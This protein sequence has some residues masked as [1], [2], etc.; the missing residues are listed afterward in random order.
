MYTVICGA[1][2]AHLRVQALAQCTGALK[3]Y[4]LHVLLE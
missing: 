4:S 2:V 1:H 3:A